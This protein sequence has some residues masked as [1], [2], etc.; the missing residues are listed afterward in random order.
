MKILCV[1]QGGFIRSVALKYWFA[2]W[3]HDA[4]AVGLE[5]CTIETLKMLCDWADEIVLAEE[6]M[7]EHL[8]TY[9]MGKAWS[10]DIGPD[11]WGAFGFK[12]ALEDIKVI[13]E[14]G[15][16]F[17]DRGMKATA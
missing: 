3:G 17:V 9:R 15:A 4:I 10:A 7:A 11:K 12:D 1:C 14:D 13:L 6:Y 2:K 16:S 8:P 5:N